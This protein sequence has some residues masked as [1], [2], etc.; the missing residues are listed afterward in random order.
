[1]AVGDVTNPKRVRMQA[2]ERLDT[3]DA[4]AFSIGAREHLDAYSRAVE[5][6]PRNVGSTTPTGFIFQG[7]GMT[8]NPTAPTDNK[9]RVT[10]PLG[11]AFDADGR[12]LIKENGIQVD[13]TLSAGNSQIYAYYIE[14]DSDTTVRRR[15]SVTSPY[16]ESGASIPTKVKSNVGFFTRAGDQTSI[17]ASDV[18]NGATTPLCFL[19]VA[20]N[21]AG[22]VTMTGYNA[23]TAPNGAFATN[24]ITSVVTPTTLPQANTSNGSVVTMH[25]L[26]NAALYMAGQAIWKGSKNFTPSAANN[27]GAYTLPTVGI[28]GLFD[29]QAEGTLT[30]TTRW[31]DWQQNVRFLVDHN[32][33]PGGQLTTKNDDWV[34]DPIPV[35]IS[36]TAGYKLAGSAVAQ[37]GVPFG[38][39]L[40][41]SS[42]SWLIPICESVPHGA[43]VTSIIVYYTSTNAANT[44]TAALNFI[45]LGGGGLGP[46]VSR[47]VTTPA[48]S[49]SF[50]VMSTPTSGHGPQFTRDL[51]RLGIILT[52]TIAGGS[53]SVIGLRVTYTVPPVGWN[54]VLSSITDAEIT[55]ELVSFQ[56]PFSGLNQ[57]TV[58]FDTAS[59]SLTGSIK[60]ETTFDLFLD[61][62]LVHTT[63][64]IL[65][66]GTVVSGGSSAGCFFGI[67][68]ANPFWGIEHL[69]GEANW[70][71]ALSDDDLGH[72]TLDTGV[73]FSNDTVYRIKLEFQGANRN[74]SGFGRTRVWI[75]GALV[76]TL[77]ETNPFTDN[78]AKVTLQ[79]FNFVAAVGPWTIS[80]GRLRRVWNHLA[81]GDNV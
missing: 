71:L 81:A 77:T 6:V 55:S 41:T 10:S 60:L 16:T 37:T 79:F 72:L 48:A 14:D 47:T 2:N 27:F 64:L 56:P 26:A 44:L 25:G 17:V 80:L 74:S 58:K 32:G 34:S 28:D 43:F 30:P 9:I 7:F 19:G 54:T 11:V 1:M 51:E 66:T 18:V 62:N 75:N 20:N 61:A 73:A 46:L 3:V 36:P 70:K 42:D 5:A 31:R 24:R 59:S 13:L 38:V 67:I 45:D 21:T 15:I 65:K 57:R 76:G 4:D 23:T 12:L 8:L 53:I 68:T 52:C 49:S 78:V 39:S 40:T 69:Q 22:A 33:F 35:S 63:E 29:S 50:D